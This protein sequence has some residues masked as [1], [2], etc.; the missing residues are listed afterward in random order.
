VDTNA[1]RLAVVARDGNEVSYNPALLKNLT[2]QSKVFREEVR[3]ISEGER[4]RF[5]ATAQDFH[6][7]KGD[8]ATVERISEG[9]SLTIRSDQGKSIA[10]SEEQSRNIDYGYIADRMPHRGV[11]RVIVSSDAPQLTT[12]QKDLAR[13]SG[14]TRD[15]AIYTSDGRGLAQGKSIPGTEVAAQALQPGMN[16]S[17]VVAPPETLVEGFSR[18]R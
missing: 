5:T 16:P 1:N 9:R 3:D 11:D 13:L 12:M 15:L 7:R 10:L 17:P 6:L 8:F 4:I 18:G 2:S 14:Q